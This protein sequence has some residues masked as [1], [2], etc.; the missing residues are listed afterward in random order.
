M[1]VVSIDPGTTES[2]IVVWDGQKIIRANFVPN[3]SMVQL[4]TEPLLLLDSSDL[5]VWAMAELYVE[6]IASYGMAV[7][8]EVFETCLW[9]GRFIERWDGMGKRH[10]LIYRR[11]VKLHHCGTARAKD[12]NIRAELINKYGAPG[13]KKAPGLTYGIS[14]HL[15]SAFAIATY[16]TET[17]GILTGG[18]AEEGKEGREAH[19]SLLAPKQS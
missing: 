19:Q 11:D 15:W 18:K 1:I 8:K 14:K 16:V 17:N 9:I 13:T 6:M 3:D 4:L 2:A 10:K 12:A 5:R 7:G